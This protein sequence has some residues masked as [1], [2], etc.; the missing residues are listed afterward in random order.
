MRTAYGTAIKT[1]CPRDC[2]DACGMKRHASKDGRVRKVSGDRDHMVSRGKLCPK[3]ALAYNGAW[4]DPDA[5]PH[6]PASAGGPERDAVASLSV[7]W[8]EAH[9]VNRRPADD[10]ARRPTRPKP[11]CHTHYTGTCS[12][13][14]RKFS[15]PFFQSN[16]RYRG[17]SRYGL[18]Q[19]RSR[20]AQIC[21][22]AIL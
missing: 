19:G 12:A 21:S 11:S 1:T 10:G 6:A 17:R 7:S 5:A 22:L 13:I 4:I 2:Y 9:R 3:C 16:R 8:D 18:Q 20:S 14:A 15:Q